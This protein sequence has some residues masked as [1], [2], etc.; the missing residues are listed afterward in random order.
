MPNFPFQNKHLTKK[1]DTIVGLEVH[2][3]AMLGETGEVAGAWS[4]GGKMAWRHVDMDIW[5]E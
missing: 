1:E 5:F 3:V 4:Q 2:K